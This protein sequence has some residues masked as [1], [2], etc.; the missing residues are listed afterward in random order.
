MKF[1]NETLNPKFYVKDKMIPAL[2][3]KLIDITKDFLANVPIKLPKID[4]IQLTGSLANYN[5]TP[6]S[7]LDVHILL[8]FNKIDE[9]TDLVKAAL[10]GSPLTAAHLRC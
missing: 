10:D 7:D 8:D 5:Y 9:D 4:D 1:Y 2:R 3:K 6:K